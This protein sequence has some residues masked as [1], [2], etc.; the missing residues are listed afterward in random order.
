MEIRDYLYSTD[1][2]LGDR[3]GKIAMGND[4]WGMRGDTHQTNAARITGNHVY[5]GVAVR[6]QTSQIMRIQCLRQRRK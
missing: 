6:T 5:A 3:I 2:R 4:R 1:V